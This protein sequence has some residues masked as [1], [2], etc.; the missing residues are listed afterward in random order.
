MTPIDPTP[1]LNGSRRLPAGAIP[2]ATLDPGLYRVSP[3]SARVVC[4]MPPGRWI[5]WQGA[6]NTVSSLPPK[7]SG[8]VVKAVVAHLDISQAELARRIGL[9]PS[10]VTLW[11][12]SKQH[13]GP[14]AAQAIAG[15]LGASAREVDTA[16]QAG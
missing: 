8:L 16:R 10:V 12:K 15:L 9:S 6:G 14:N 7:T 2:L 3:E 4:L 1:Y 11:A 5:A 13:P